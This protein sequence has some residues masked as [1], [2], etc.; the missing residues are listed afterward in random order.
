VV[1]D[2]YWYKNVS[3]TLP[4]APTPTSATMDESM[5]ITDPRPDEMEADPIT[6]TKPTNKRKRQPHFP[7]DTKK[8]D[9]PPD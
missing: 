5:E 1:L 9:D 3:E 6:P 8:D 7:T 2:L 4:R